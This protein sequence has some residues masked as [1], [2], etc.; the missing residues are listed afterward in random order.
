MYKATLVFR[1]FPNS[2]ERLLP[3]TFGDTCLTATL[4]EAAARQASLVWFALF[5]ASKYREQFLFD[6]RALID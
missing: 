4:Y 3:T 5:P 2:T 1:L 6:S